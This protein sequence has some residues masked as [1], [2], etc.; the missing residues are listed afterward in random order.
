[1]RVAGALR[2]HGCMRAFIRRRYGFKHE[3]LP[4]VMSG[5]AEALVRDPENFSFYEGR[6]LCARMTGA[7]LGHGASEHILRIGHAR[8]HAQRGSCVADWRCLQRAAGQLLGSHGAHW[9]CI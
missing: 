3:C 9:G 1:M 6:S 8:H 4:D 5:R 7:V 2:G